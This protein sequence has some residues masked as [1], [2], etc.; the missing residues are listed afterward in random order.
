MQEILEL[1]LNRQEANSLPCYDERQISWPLCSSGNYVNLSNR[2]YL[3]SCLC[4]TTRYVAVENTGL[5][6][7]LDVTL[8]FIFGIKAEKVQLGNQR[9]NPEKKDANFVLV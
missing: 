3:P 6:A 2:V 9:S 8:D 4:M 7:Y 1:P 5:S